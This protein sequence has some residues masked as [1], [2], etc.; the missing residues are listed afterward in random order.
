MSQPRYR[1][2]KEKGRKNEREKNEGFKMCIIFLLLSQSLTFS[3]LSIFIS[4]NIPFFFLSA[5]ST[6]FMFSY[7]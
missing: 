2:G 6:I 7:Y 5:L 3:Y 1:K 4:Y